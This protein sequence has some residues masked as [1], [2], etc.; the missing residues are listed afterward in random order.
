MQKPFFSIIIPTKNRP[1]SLRE[2]LSS[3]V[4]AGE[5]LEAYL[6]P[7][8]ISYEIIVCDDSTS[9]GTHKLLELEFPCV[10]YMQGAHQGP[11]ANRNKGAAISQGEWLIFTDDDCIAHP[12]WLLHFYK[13]AHQSLA[14]EGC[15]QPKGSFLDLWKCPINDR[16][17][18]FWSA[19]I[20]IKKDLFTK[21]GGFDSFFPYP[22]YED[23]DLYLRLKKETKIAFIKEAII[24]HPI[25]CFGFEEAMK[26][27]FRVLRSRAYLLAKHNLN[28]T[29]KGW[30][31]IFFN[32]YRIHGSQ[33]LHSLRQRLWKS[34]LL[35]SFI[36]VFLLPCLMFWTLK[37]HKQCPKN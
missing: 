10:R 27:E 21:V 3:I 36:I 18:N 29:P 32:E 1:H 7:K 11:A 4:V 30:L 16:G 17:G 19:N 6:G 34:A 25:V 22:A 24:F 12:Q 9:Q 23:T 5:S 13:N 31:K 37:Y 14:L 26:K 28:N 15:I 33:L 8:G 35:N 20:A 2:C